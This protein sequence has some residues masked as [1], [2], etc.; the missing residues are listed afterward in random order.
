M[1]GES[2]VGVWIEEQTGEQMGEYVEVPVYEHFT[3]DRPIYW[4]RIST[5]VTRRANLLDTER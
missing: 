2:S 3:L 5:C 1:H 4:P